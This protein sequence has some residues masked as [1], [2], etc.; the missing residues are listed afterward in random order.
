[1][2]KQITVPR[3]RT[4]DL[5]D[6]TVLAR[7]VESKSFTEAARRLGLPKSA[8]S[9]RIARLEEAL[10][11]R[12]LQRTTRHLSLTEAGARY[13]DAAVA[14][15]ARLD[16][17]TSEVTAA[18]AAPRGRVRITAPV[19]V[20]VLALADVIARFVA[21]YPEVQVEATLTNR[22]VDLVAEGIDLA[23]RAS[24]RL[25]PS[26]IARKLGENAFIVVAAPAY[27]K[28][29][30]A[31]KTPAQLAR[32]ACVLFRPRDGR[33]R[34]SLAG[35]GGPHEIDVTGPVGADDLSFVRQAV[36][37]GAGIGF[38][39]A[40]ACADDLARGKL[41]RLFPELSSVPNAVHVVYPSARYLPQSVAL[42]RD[43]IVAEIKVL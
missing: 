28:K 6:V 4:I 25:D 16:E 39:P 3:K 32:H 30:G 10:G 27:L 31:P 2:P 1:M 34:W 8:V 29:H 38:I 36:R 35:P 19:D 18:G 9:R 14:A 15:L 12:L 43:F 7:V 23:V 22:T 24:R 17:A 42:L 5:N 41:V 26:L 37:A 20:G 21:K 40:P 11:V 33:A 13:H